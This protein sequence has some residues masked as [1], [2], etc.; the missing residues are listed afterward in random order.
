[1]GLS[2]VID[3]TTRSWVVT[4]ITGYVLLLVWVLSILTPPILH[5]DGTQQLAVFGLSLGA[6]GINVAQAAK[7]VGIAQLS[8]GS[9]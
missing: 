2:I 9:K 4:T 3:P 5:L 7:A 1:M 6:L 8:S